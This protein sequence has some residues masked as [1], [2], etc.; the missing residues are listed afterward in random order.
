MYQPTL[1]P[2]KTRCV[3]QPPAHASASFPSV[4]G[5]TFLRAI[6]HQNLNRGLARF[7]FQPYAVQSLKDRRPVGAFRIGCVR[8]LRISEI[9]LRGPFEMQDCAPRATVESSERA[10][11]ASRNCTFQLA[12]LCRFHAY[13]Q[14]VQNILQVSCRVEFFNKFLEVRPDSPDNLL[15]NSFLLECPALHASTRLE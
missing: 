7:Q 14:D 9:L 8:A 2:P 6:N 13:I 15:V 12:D 1:P 4:F 10:V 11:P 5:G 3:S